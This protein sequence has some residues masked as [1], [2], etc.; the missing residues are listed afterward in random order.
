MLR[1]QETPIRLRKL[2]WPNTLWMNCSD[3][4]E[5]GYREPGNEKIQ[6]PKGTRYKKHQWEVWTASL[7]DRIRL[8][9]L[10][11]S[12]WHNQIVFYKDYDGNFVKGGLEGAQEW[13]QRQLGGWQLL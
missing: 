11:V 3:T 7:G 10:K 2:D 13:R 5:K 1:E 12:Q 8:K 6:R 4:Q 9:G